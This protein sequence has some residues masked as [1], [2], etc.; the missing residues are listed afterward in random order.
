MNLSQQPLASSL[1]FLRSILAI[2][3]SVMQLGAWLVATAAGSGLAILAA[4]QAVA[5]RE[6]DMTIAYNA[7]NY[8][9][10]IAPSI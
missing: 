3:W 1:T 2:C 5:A 7:L 6:S 8:P 4:S 10:E 9:D